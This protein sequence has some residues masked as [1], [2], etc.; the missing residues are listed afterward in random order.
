[1]SDERVS[2][3]DRRDRNGWRLFSD[4]DLSNLKEAV[5]HVETKE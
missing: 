1:L 2:L 5:E 3:P 4:E